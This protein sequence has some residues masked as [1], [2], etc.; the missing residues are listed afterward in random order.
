MAQGVISKKYLID[1][2]NAIRVKLNSQSAYTPAQM[3]AAIESITGEISGTITKSTNTEQ[4]LITDT[5][6]T[7][8]CDALRTK[9]DDQTL[10]FTPGEIAD[11]ILS[12]EPAVTTRIYGAEWDG[13]SRTDWTRTDD[14]VGFPDPNPAVSNGNGSSPFDNLMPWSGMKRVE[15]SEAGT[16]VEIPKFWYK[17]TFSGSKM[18]LQIADGEV[19]GFSVSPAHMD[20][21]DGKGERDVIYVGAYHCAG[22][23]KSTTGV[24]PRAG[25]TRATARTNI[26]ALGSDIWQWDYA[27]LWTI[28]MLYLVE[29]ADWNSQAK[30][31]YGGG[32][33]SST[34]NSGLCDAMTYHTGTNAS[35]RTTY[36]HT[37]Y[38]YIEDLWGNV[39]DWC[40]GI[41][42]SSSN[43]YAIKNPAN[44][45]DSSGGTLVGTRPTSSGYISKYAQSTASGFDWFIYPSAV[46]GSESTYAT[47]HCYYD[48][49]GVVLYVGGAYYQ[50]QD[51]GLFYTGG[52]VAAWGAGIDLGSR[53]L[54]LP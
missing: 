12:I 20:R 13:S 28:R 26:H 10:R 32:N 35:S 3:A 45:S 50:S 7:G 40:D 52:D 16:L 15:D 31:G 38:R 1:M 11:G 24:P 9:L 41:Y 25:I 29:Y 22:T 37:R 23:Y 17:W 27:T 46:S 44:F 39:V 54:K 18:K 30:I 8:I 49:S 6:M 48:S 19:D 14:A 21:G 42:F 5:V 47:D 51:I 2:A 33:N 53:I 36:G 43:V 4:G 34:E